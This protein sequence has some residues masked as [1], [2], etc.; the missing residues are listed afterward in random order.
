MAEANARLIAAA[1]ALLDVSVRALAHYDRIRPEGHDDTPLMRD[2]RRAIA[3]ALP[4]N[5]ER[6]R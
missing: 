1:P 5:P 6:T 2:L 3:A 4:T